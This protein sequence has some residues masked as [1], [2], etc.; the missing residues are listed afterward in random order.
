MYFTANPGVR[1]ER[2]NAQYRSRRES[3]NAPV[4]TPIGVIGVRDLRGGVTRG[5]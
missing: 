1:V 2:T 3:Q 5:L 4:T